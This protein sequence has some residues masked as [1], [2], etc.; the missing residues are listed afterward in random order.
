MAI[1]AEPKPGTFPGWTLA[2]MLKT[3][4]IGIFVRYCVVIVDWYVFRAERARQFCFQCVEAAGL[5]LLHDLPRNYGTQITIVT[6][7]IIT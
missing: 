5:G 3:S 1:G 6:L 4:F 7:I 2:P